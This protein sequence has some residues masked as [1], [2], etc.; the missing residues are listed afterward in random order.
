MLVMLAVMLLALCLSASPALAAD[1]NGDRTLSPYFV[2]TSDSPGVD[3]L[4]L[5]STSAQ[6]RIAGVIADVTVT[7]VYRNT[8]TRTLEAIYVFP[9]STRAAVYGMTMTIGERVVQAQI[10]EREQARREYE[11]ARQEG[12]TASLLEQE[13]PNVFT[14]NVA[15]IQ[16]GDEIVVEL[17]YTE[18]LVPTDGV[19]EFVYPAVVGPRYAN[20][21]AAT[22]PAT[23]RFI[24]SPYLP[25]GDSVPYE[26][27]LVT[28]IAAGMP[29]REITSPSHALAVAYDDLRTATVTLQPGT[30][31]GGNRDYVLRYRLAGDAIATGLLLYEGDTENFFLMLV[32]P[33]ARVTPAA[34]PPREFV[35]IVD[36]SGS[37]HGFPLSITK[38]LMR[39]LLTGLRPEDRFNVLLFAG[40][41][42]VLAEQPLPATE[43]NIARA[44]N[45]IDNEH[46][47]GGTELLPALRRALALPRPAGMSRSVVIATDGYVGVE[48]EAFDLIRG[49]LDQ[50]NMY[51]FGIGSG[52]NRYLIEGLAR[53]G[54]GE[55]FI[56]T[57]PDEAN[58]QAEKFRR[59]IAAPVLTGVQVQAAGFDVY[60]VEPQSVPDV[61]AQRPL[62]IFGKWRGTLQ[63]ELAV[64]GTAGGGAFS[65]RVPVAEFRPRTDHAA[66]RYLWARQRIAMLDDYNNL[67]ARNELKDELIALGLNYNLM[68]RYTSFVAIDRV[69]RRNENGEPVTVQQTLPL[70]EGVENSAVGTAMPLSRPVPGGSFAARHA[71]SA[72]APATM[73]ADA[74]NAPVVGNLFTGTVAKE[75][76]SIVTRGALADSICVLALAVD[77]PAVAVATVQRMVTG[78]LAG[79][80]PATPAALTGPGRKLMVELAVDSDGTVRAVRQTGG[81]LAPAQAAQLL[82]AMRGWR[83]D[84]LAAAFPVTVVMTLA[85]W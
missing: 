29:I 52:V 65:V 13:R 67:S 42:T 4:P 56:V 31:N 3:Q 32:Q 79:M 28:T 23:D 80:L 54:Q 70:P 68:T 58:G 82:A 60:D 17:K 35:F 41:S 43:E 38:K 66:L 37:M 64:T 10:R 51:A 83:F 46:G 39:D 7:Q 9:G 20:Q 76:D 18:L 25:Q 2:V 19:Y 16:P 44:V 14:M 53:C 50:A 5:K 73:P 61:L 59:Y 55:P 75:A 27:N 74:L 36:V 40:G 81:D 33:P 15:N 24:A 1:G 8:G 45:A 6:V 78:Q 71:V 12:R 48:R 63:G 47:G 72:S 69:I 62:V 30:G 22:A 49:S 34:I 85:V 57:K 26:F 21:N 11:Q 84:G 77:Q